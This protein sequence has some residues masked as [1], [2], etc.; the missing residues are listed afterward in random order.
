MQVDGAESTEGA[1]AGNR[2]RRPGLAVPRWARPAGNPNRV[3]RRIKL[4]RRLKWLAVVL[5]LLFAVWSNYPFIPNPWTLLFRQP[6]GDATA[7]SAPGRWAMHGAN[8]QGTNFIPAAAAPQG[9]IAFTVDVDGGVRS[10]P[11]VADGVIYIGGQSRIAAFDAATGRMIWERPASGPVHGIPAVAGNSLYIGMLDKR[12]LA[13]DL[14][15]GRARWEYEGESPFPGPVAVQDGI[16]YAGSRGFGVHALDAESGGLLWKVNTG[17]PVVAPVAVSDGKMF[18]ASTSGTMLIRHSGT[19]DKRARIRTSASLVSP[20]VVADGRAYLLSEGDLM[21]FDAGVRELPGRYPAELVWAQLWLWQ[22]PLPAPPEH[23]GL[24]WRVSPG[25][26][27]G[28]FIHPP[29]VTREALYLGTGAGEV[30]ALNPED[31]RVLWRMQAGAPIAAPPV[32]AGDLLVVA[33]ED[34]GIRGIDRFSREE[35]WALSLGSPLVAP[36]SYAAGSV[37]AHTQDGKLHVI[38]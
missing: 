21:S 3:Q 31:G 10:A 36:L 13:L 16:V 35:Q 30:V 37:Y 22:F 33:H 17:G 27:M 2:P 24:Q 5:L 14:A 23:S 7:A 28:A 9:V 4:R 18:A 12:V 34:G 1:G 20:P 38:R 8:P 11:A 25:E 29:A 19:G 6:D 26:G 32:A 15:S